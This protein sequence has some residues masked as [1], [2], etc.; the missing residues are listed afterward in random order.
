[1]STDNE[2]PAETPNRIHLDTDL[3]TW[4]DE[5]LVSLTEAEFDRWIDIE[6]AKSGVE[7]LPEEP[8]PKPEVTEVEA[9]VEIFVVKIGS[10]EF[11]FRTSEAA[12]T[13]RRA[14]D[15]IRS[16]R[17]ATGGSRYSPPRYIRKNAEEVGPTT[18]ET[19]WVVSAERR[20]ETQDRASEEEEIFVA[21]EEKQKAYDAAIRE[22]K[23]I[24]QEILDIVT[25]ARTRIDSRARAQVEFERY[26]DLSEND[27]AMAL[28]FL[29]NVRRDAIEILGLDAEY[30]K[31]I[32]SSPDSV[33]LRATQGAV[34]RIRGATEEEDEELLDAE[35]VETEL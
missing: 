27:R 17:I 12:E 10:E 33:H 4:S 19:E 29:G 5:D 21:W 13:V 26:L 16:D 14:L 30:A 9:D 20:A 11:D 25:L 7:L 32:D 8:G 3:S 22:R 15:S 28:R 6:S 35:P 31:A 2:G 1:M 18:V 24:D 23:A 34:Q